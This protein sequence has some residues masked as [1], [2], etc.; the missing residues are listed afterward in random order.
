MT[1]D[2]QKKPGKK[3]QKPQK[4]QP[5][6]VQEAQEAVE[7][8][9]EVQQ[10]PGPLE[11]AREEAERYK[12]QLMRTA[13]EYDNFKKRTQKEKEALSAEIK[14]L[15]IGQMLPVLDNLERAATTCDQ[16]EGETLREGLCM[17]LRQMEE[18]FSKLGVEKIPDVGQPFNPDWHEAV[19]HIEDEA[20]GEN[21]VA[22]AFQTGYRVG[23]R[24]IRH[25]MVKVAN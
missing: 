17:V 14:A 9:A 16:G 24:V 5:P 23:E 20:L 19:M 6:E 25:S 8:Q 2:E 13:A 3:A 22:E 10:Q 7:V 18:A 4:E 15:V 21:T 1:K 12:D 11:Q